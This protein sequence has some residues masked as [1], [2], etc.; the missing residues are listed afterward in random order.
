MTQQQKRWFE[1]DEAW[2]AY[3]DKFTPCL[4]RPV[5]EGVKKALSRLRYTTAVGSPSEWDDIIDMSRIKEIDFSFYESFNRNEKIRQFPEFKQFVW[6]GLDFVGNAWFVACNNLTAIEFPSTI[7]SIGS[8]SFQ[9]CDLREIEIPAAVNS[10]GERAFNN[11][12]NLKTVRCLGTTPAEIGSKVFEVNSWPSEVVTEGFKIYVPAE[13]VA[14]YK[15]KWS[16]YKDYIVAASD[17]QTFPKRVTTT[18]VGELASKLG[19]ETVMDGNYLEGLKGAYWNID[20]LTV[21]GPLNGVDVGVLR[22]LA[23]ADVNNSDPTYGRLRYLNLYNARLKKDKDHPYQCD[24][25]NDYLENDDEVGEYMFYNC[26]QLETV[27]LPKAATR[28]RKYALCNAANLKHLAVGDKTVEYN[29]HITKNV[30][31]I[32]ELVFLTEQKADNNTSTFFEWSTDYESWGVPIN[33]VY[34]PTSLVKEYAG[35]TAIIKYASSIS[36]PFEDDTVM[37]C[38]VDKGHY[39][40]SSIAKMTNIDGILSSEV[41]TF[42]ELLNFTEMTDLGSA[43][44]GCRNLQSVSLPASLTNIGYSAFKGCT[45]MQSIYVSADSAATLESGAFRDLPANFRIY[46]P[47]ALTSHYRTEWAEYASHIIA[48]ERRVD[49][50]IEV[51][52]TEPNTLAQAL[53]LTVDYGAVLLDDDDD[54]DHEWRGQM[55]MD[56]RGEYS[57]INKLKVNGPIS[58]ADLSVIKFLGGRIPWNNVKN[59]LGRLEYVDLYNTELKVSNW[60]SAMNS[61]GITWVREE[62]SLPDESLSDMP[63]IRTIILPRTCERVYRTAVGGNEALEVLVVGDDTKEFEWDAVGAD[64]SLLR[65]YMLCNQ[66]PDVSKLVTFASYHPTLETIFVRPSLYNDYIS[67]PAFTGNSTKIANNISKGVFKDDETF[68]AFAAHGAATDDDIAGINSVDG[69]FK[70]HTGITDLSMLRMS[71]VDTLRAGDMK[72]LTQLQKIALPLTLKEIESGSFSGAT[73][74][75]WADFLLCD[76]AMTD[77]LRNNKLLR[78]AGFSKNTI[79]YMPSHYGQTDEVNVVV[80]DTT[81]VM[82]CTNF[83]LVDGHDYD[84]LYSFKAQKVENN[85]TLSKSAVPYTICLPYDLDIPIG[86]KAYKMSGRSDNEL[87][88]TQTLDRLETLQ[89][90]LIWADQGDAT[91]GTS[92]D[93]SIP[94]SGGMTYGRQHDAPGFSMRGTLYGISNA[95]A[96]ELGAYTLQNDGKWHPVLSDTDEHR[97]ASILPYR[98]YLLQNR[99]ARN[100][101]I[102]MTL[103]DATGIEQLRTIDSDGTERVYDLNGRQLS[104]PTKGINVMNGKK[105]IKK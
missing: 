80:G 12:Y 44:E 56:I 50:I 67:D 39:F 65:M 23:G 68:L 72:A 47:K 99:N 95:E 70:N 25:F 79:C 103:E 78:D 54:P 59:M 10:I 100:R 40:P 97:A 53:G 81:G 85:R 92:G 90:Y 36:S 87:I 58:G 42:N 21:S 73:D 19:L 33:A 57:H 101:A 71:S 34:T 74:L 66:K 6:A 31:A 4:V 20:S 24:G 62:N 16:E 88:F 91:L 29:D 75:H 63:S 51:T 45:G 35:E 69:W 26:K 55:I 7:K 38:F 2:A 105:I 46:V 22:F 32:D 15:E 82:T 18:K 1:A 48:D 17:A 11:N 83:M 102:G 60:R 27:I 94:A 28:L 14:A 8:Y 49:D 76:S 9:N 43:F 3:K 89:P 98:A 30:M 5:D 37:R 13:A 64:V 61:G 84:V 86:A 77:K 96:S 104:A 52:L 41:R 93:I